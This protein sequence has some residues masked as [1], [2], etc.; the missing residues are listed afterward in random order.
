MS[1]GT[2]PPSSAPPVPLSLPCQEAKPRNASW[3][4][5]GR[6]GM[7]FPGRHRSIE[8]ASYLL[9]SSDRQH[10]PKVSSFPLPLGVESL[11]EQKTV[12]LNWEALGGEE[13]GVGALG[14]GE[15]H[16]GNG[17]ALMQ[18]RKSPV[19]TYTWRGTPCLTDLSELRTDLE[20][21]VPWKSSGPGASFTLRRQV[22]RLR[23]WRSWP[24]DTLQPSLSPYLT[25]RLKGPI[26]G[27]LVVSLSTDLLPLSWLSRIVPSQ[28]NP[29][30][31]FKVSL[32]FP[33][34]RTA[35]CPE[36]GRCCFWNRQWQE[37]GTNC[38]SELHGFGFLCRFL[39]LLWR[40]RQIALA[41]IIPFV[42]RKTFS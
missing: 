34:P 24:A 28:P 33:N 22:N 23:S 10:F 27:K 30:P 17:G 1:Q 2:S 5:W 32:L 11:G 8:A 16:P 40:W 42:F 41:G 12:I 14:V 29:C 37:K 7:S 19:E 20:P 36:S 39:C 38:Y 21:E 9:P 6:L 18:S 35:E 3:T 4:G 13:G 25:P 26:L 15:Q 31:S